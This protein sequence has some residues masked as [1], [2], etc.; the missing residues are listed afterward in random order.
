MVIL[1]L[2]LPTMS[3]KDIYY[4]LKEISPQVKV[5]ISSG[6]AQDGQADELIANGCLGFIQKPYNIEALSTR[7]MGIFSAG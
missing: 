1:D 7:I 3:G 6:C 2:I 4:R 5:L